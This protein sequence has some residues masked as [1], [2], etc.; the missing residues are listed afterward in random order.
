[1]TYD[2]RSCYHVKNNVTV[3]IINLLI[4]AITDRDSK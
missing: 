2:V 1:M 3:I 4:M